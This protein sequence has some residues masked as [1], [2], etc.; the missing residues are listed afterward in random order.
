MKLWLHSLLSIIC[1]CALTACKIDGEEEITIRDDGSAQVRVH[2]IL[3]YKAFSKNDAQQVHSLLTEIA[4]RHPELSLTENTSLPHG[5]YCQE[6]KL[7]IAFSSVLEIE[8]IILE[9]HAHFQSLASQSGD[10]N[11]SITMVEALL[12][13]I[14]AGVHADAIRYDRTVNLSPLFKGKITN[15]KVLG[16]AEF[17]YILTTPLAA[18]SHN[19]SAVT[20]QGKTLTWRIP[21]REYYNKPFQLKTQHARHLFTLLWTLLT[22]FCLALIGLTFW[23]RRRRI[24]RQSDRS[25]TSDEE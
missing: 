23:W 20:N 5:K 4:N 9:E 10:E 17:R 13:N 22:G 24:R 16:N 7:N 15:G 18:D 2:Y 12:G 8:R 1:L 11:K 19:A 6:L 25:L 3:P 14:E 21:L